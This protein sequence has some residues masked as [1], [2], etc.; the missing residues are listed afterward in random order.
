MQKTSENMK[1][2][3]NKWDMSSA[4]HVI[5]GETSIQGAIIEV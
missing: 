2:Y 3:P 5:S 1:N 4:G